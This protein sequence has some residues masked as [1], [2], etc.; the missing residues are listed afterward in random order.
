MFFLLGRGFWLLCGKWG[1]LGGMGDFGGFKK[2]E[3]LRENCMEWFYN[4]LN[5]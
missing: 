5:F 3:G 2:G 4:I 1:I